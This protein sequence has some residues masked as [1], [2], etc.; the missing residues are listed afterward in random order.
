MALKEKGPK[1]FFSRFGGEQPIPPEFIAAMQRAEEIQAVPNDVPPED[2]SDTIVE[3]E[4]TTNRTGERVRKTIKKIPGNIVLLAYNTNDKGQPVQVIRTLLPTGTLAVFP[5]ATQD[6]ALRDL[7]NGWSIQEVSVEG[8]FIDDVFTP[9]LFTAQE[10]RVSRP[11]PL[12]EEFRVSAPTTYESHR[13]EG[14]AIE[15]V[16]GVGDLEAT[17]K[18]ETEF[19]KDV[20]VTNRDDGSIPTLID[21]ETTG[22]GQL[23][24]ITK[25]II[26]GISV[27]TP[28]ALTKVKSHEL[29][30]GRSE[31]DITTI[32]EVLALDE[33]D[34]EVPDPVPPRFRLASPATTHAFT[35]IGVAT[36]PVIGTGDLSKSEKQIDAFIKRLSTTNRDPADL[37]VSLVSYKLT[38]DQQVETVTETLD[39][40]LQTIP[41]V[42][43][44]TTEANV[45]NLGNNLSLLLFGEVP[46]LFPQESFS[47][48]IPD[49]IPPRFRVLSP[50]TTTE[51]TVAGTAA[52]PVLGTGDLSKSERQLTEFKKRLSTTN[53]DPSALPVSLVSYKLTADKQIETITETLDEG[54]QTIPTVDETTTEAN[55]D[56]LGN[57]LSLLLF[58]E[59]P[60]LFDAITFE[61]NRPD[62]LPEEFR[63]A[64]PATTE[65]HTV[66]GTATLPILVAGDL[67]ASERQINEFAKE[68]SLTNRDDGEIPTLIDLTTSEVKQLETH[69]KD[70][71]TGES[72]VTPDALTRVLSRA[73]GDGRSVQ[74]I[75]TIDDVFAR[76]HRAI[77]IPDPIPERFKVAVPVSTEELTEIGVIATPTLGTGELEK[78][79]EEVSEFEIR[80]R[81]VGRSLI[82]L[83]VSLVSYRMTPEGQIETITETLDTGVQTI[84]PDELT[85]E[86]DTENLGN[87][88]SLLKVGLVPD[89]F[90][91]EEFSTEI[92]DP[93]PARFKVASPAVT[94]VVTGAGAP[95]PP[96]LG[97]G[98]L[99]ASSKAVGEFKVRNSV[100]NR[101]PL[102]LPI[103]LTSY[104]L[105]K[106]G[107]IGTVVETLDTGIQ[108]IPTPDEL[109]VDAS[110]ENIGN[111][112]SILSVE[113]VP[114]LFDPLSFAVSRPDSLPEE[115]RVAAPATTE[116]HV[117][118]GTATLPVLG[119][120]DLSA[121]QRQLTEF[122]REVSLTNRDDGSIPTLIDLKT[123]Q[124]KQIVTVTKDII[125]G[126]SAVTPTALRDVISKAIG[127]GRSV[128]EISLIDTVFENKTSSKEIQDLV[129]VEFRGVVPTY[130]TEITIAGTIVDPPVFG[131]GDLEKTEIQIDVFTKKVRTRGRA[132]ISL[133]ITLT[134]GQKLVEK[135]GVQLLANSVITLGAAGTL[136]IP[137]GFLVV[138]AE[139]REI[140]GGMEI[141]TSLVVP[142][143][144][145][146][147][148]TSRPFDEEMQ[149]RTLREEQIVDPTYVCVDGVG[150]TESL[151]AVDQFHARRIR[152]TKAPTAVSEA[153][154]LLSSV[155]APFQFPGTLDVVQSASTNAWLG[156]RSVRAEFVEQIIKT[157]WVNSP[158]KPSIP[159]S[160]ILPDSIVIVGAARIERFQNVLHDAYYAIGAISQFFPATKPS[161]SEYN[162]GTNSGT[163]TQTW[164]AT[165]YTP[166]TGYQIGE[167]ISASSSGVNVR[168][169]ITNVGIDNSITG[170]N[171]IFSSGSPLAS[172]TNPVAATGG[173][174]GSGAMFNLALATLPVYIPGT[175]WVGNPRV[176]AANVTPTEIKDQWKIQTRT[177][178]MR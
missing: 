127:D 144:A 4:T 83:P 65:K 71:I 49:P 161:F 10:Y 57:N 89:V 97:T 149:V 54:L 157:W 167:I 166:G 14:I 27:V 140:G 40:G 134:G 59:V 38:P 176:I 135:Y 44:T 125:T 69:T 34:I 74:E 21:L 58:G 153:T 162:N 147:V 78:S 82:S 132:G 33:F 47:I 159:Y 26:S 68:T 81:T 15:P 45:D 16:L 163:V 42:D 84:T 94:H 55:V 76:E 39:E 120:G 137:T 80:T 171:I 156:Y 122:T 9:Q 160:E 35:E 73:I 92:V 56:N 72:I 87:N 6:V 66:A 133:P 31:Q 154:A 175:K 53:R 141:A 170:Y 103:V 151:R 70:I 148:Q 41:T 95:A 158:I 11:D 117:I 101:D 113:T 124:Y 37:P 174:A 93:V 123:N 32:D 63:V 138:E 75:I 86:A 121:E 165:L 13:E 118:A 155:F 88:T 48:E 23:A 145:W 25:D 142:T 2:L 114:D 131:V 90:P 22:E 3:S 104:K 17:E 139:K 52:L 172:P 164:Y 19:V 128:Q 36:E 115:F 129:P 8:V 99:A 60:D 85:V 152:I 169:K 46:D 18:Q 43:E 116:K 12:P 177:V 100:T 130:T 102:D 178:I 30:D 143:T 105:T 91:D 62:A 106:D 64:A 50:A 126:E 96:V 110:V 150:F 29:G 61:V 119:A 136:T 108:T 111:D 112:T 5:D 173:G 107:Q 1:L 20:S 51:E 109:T 24:T 28:D 67:S 7:G 77:T 79:I 98:D 146:P 168:M